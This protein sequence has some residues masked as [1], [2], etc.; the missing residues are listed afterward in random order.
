MKKNKSNPSRT[1]FTSGDEAL[2]TL[3]EE[4]RQKYPELAEK[5]ENLQVSDQGGDR[6]AD[7]VREALPFSWQNPQAFSQA[8]GFCL[9]GNYLAALG[10]FSEILEVEP[11]A[12]PVY[13]LLGYVCGSM[14]KHKM[15]VDYYRKAIKLK[16]DYP[17]VYYDL[18]M[19]YWMLG[20]EAKAYTTLKEAVVRAPDFTIADHWLNFA[21]DNLGRFQDPD[22]LGEKEQGAKNRA[23]AQ[24]YYLLGQACL[25]NGLN[26]LARTFFKHAVRLRQEFA[27]AFYELGALHI[28]K[29]RNPGR[30]KKYL[31]QAENLYLQRGD[32]FR[33]ML[34]H[35]L[36]MPREE[37]S[38]NEK[39]AEDWFREGLRLHNLGLFQRAVDAYKMSIAF[40]ADFLNAY[41][42]MGIAYGSMEDSGLGK[43]DSAIGAFK[44]S[45]RL[46]PDFI[47]AYTALGAAYN[48]Q[49]NFEEAIQLLED[50]SKIDPQSHHVFYYLGVARRLSGD[51]PEAIRILERAASLAPDSLQVRFTLG[52]AFLDGQQYES[53][54]EAL[55][56]TLRIRPDFS[57]A[58]FLLG[59]L[60][61]S[62]LNDSER[63]AQHLKKAEKLYAKLKDHSKVARVREMLARL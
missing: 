53:A 6:V 15:E 18:G 52:M 16:P 47:H 63:A 1:L 48:R 50:A 59:N 3:G 29:L 43:I 23:L 34:T 25:E 8:V 9:R 58:H 21:S 40:K 5:F 36:N 35:Q 33:A 42:N 7:A 38:E 14:G 45:I 10:A 30:R 13:H 24:S 37:M 55:I 62:H 41:Y 17:Q 26:A 39:A 31:D 49:G 12:Y 20:R 11:K 4:L 2:S 28:K 54:R 61:Q 51:A 56:D 22:G 19:A 60:Y 46:K 57:D 27:D 44:Q 32:S